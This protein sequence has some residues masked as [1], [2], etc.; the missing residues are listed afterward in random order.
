MTFCDLLVAQA[1]LVRQEKQSAEN[2]VA[3]SLLTKLHGCIPS[4]NIT[5]NCCLQNYIT[6]FKNEN[7]WL[8]LKNL[9]QFMKIKLKTKK[10]SANSFTVFEKTKKLPVSVLKS[11]FFALIEQMDKK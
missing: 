2:V 3:Q 6:R 4:S 11:K 10:I 5:Y 1:R 8:F 7:E 9:L